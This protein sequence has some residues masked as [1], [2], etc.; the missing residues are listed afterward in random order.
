MQIRAL[1]RRIYARLPP[2]F[3]SDTAYIESVY[4]AI[5]QRPADQGRGSFGPNALDRLSSYR[6]FGTVFPLYIDSWNGDAAAGRPFSTLHVD[7]LG[8]PLH[9]HLTWADAAWWVRQ[10]EDRGLHRDEEIEQALH[11][12]YDDYMN[13]RSLARKA[14]FVFAKNVPPDERRKVLSRIN[15]PSRVAAAS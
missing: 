4:K 1:L 13:K 2:V 8:Y 14:Y 5:L 9:G 7:E 12:K 11:R 10:F 3:E 15:R 6:I